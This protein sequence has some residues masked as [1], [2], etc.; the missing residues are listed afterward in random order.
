M[1]ISLFCVFGHVNI[2]GKLNFLQGGVS[3]VHFYSRGFLR[4]INVISTSSGDS[5]VCWIK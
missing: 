5:S 2:P 4:V 3:V 1:Y